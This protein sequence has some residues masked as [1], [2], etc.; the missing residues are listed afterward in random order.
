MILDALRERPGITATEIAT[1][2]L[3]LKGVPT[4]PETVGE[5][6]EPGAIDAADFE[7]C[8]A[9]DAGGCGGGRAA[10]GD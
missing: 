5:A 10:M 7:A 3:T 2:L 9:G 4:D 1:A 8:R 6:Q